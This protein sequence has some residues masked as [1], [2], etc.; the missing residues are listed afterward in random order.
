MEY[1]DQIVAW[2]QANP[3]ISLVIAYF[4]GGSTVW[5]IVKRFAAS[6]PSKV[7]DKLVDMIELAFN[8]RRGEFEKASAEEIEKRLPDKMLIEI[9]KLRKARW[10]ANKKE[11]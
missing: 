6:T 2:I 9:V 8:A 11:K 5:P 4:V 7:D 3:T 10:A 1:I